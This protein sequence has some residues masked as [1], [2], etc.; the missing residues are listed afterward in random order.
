MSQ[1]IAL[2]GLFDLKAITLLELLEVGA[3][4]ETE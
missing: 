3:E 4:L 2:E 1:E